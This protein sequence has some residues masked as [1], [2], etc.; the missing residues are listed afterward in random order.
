MKLTK[1]TTVMLLFALTVSCSSSHDQDQVESKTEVAKEQTSETNK[2]AT[3]DKLILNDG[4]KWK[5]DE[6]TFAGMK[7]LELTLYNFGENTSEPTLADYNNL[8]EMLANI[9]K[10]II[11]QCSMDGKDHDQLHVLL[12]P[13]LGNVDVIKNGED[14]AQAKDNVDALAAS[15]A[16]FFAH[17]EVK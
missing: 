14:S 15:I 16:Q 17:F 5:S 4:A 2:D 12:A 6:S 10:D 9:D 1:F 11:S 7:R 8:G 3:E 13:M